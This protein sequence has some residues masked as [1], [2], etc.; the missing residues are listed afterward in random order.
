MSTGEDRP[1]DGAP[2]EGASPGHRQVPNDSGPN[3]SGPN[4]SGPNASGSDGPATGPPAPAPPPSAPPVMAPPPANIWPTAPV[5]Q[6]GSGRY[7]IDVGIDVPAQD[8][9][10]AATGAVDPGYPLVHFALCITDRRRHMRL[11]N[12]VRGPVHGPIA[13]RFGQSDR[14]LLPALLADH[15]VRLLPAGK[16]PVVRAVDEVPIP[17]RRPGLVR[18]AETGE[19]IAYRRS[20]SGSSS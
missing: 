7:P 18:G 11:H 15:N 8:R 16:V 13:G 4:A 2:P 17:G 19:I 1:A 14:R 6:R 20:C 12:V 5:Q 10:L 9:P 3:A